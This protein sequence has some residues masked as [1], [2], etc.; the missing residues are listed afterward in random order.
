M[1]RKRS[2]TPARLTRARMAGEDHAVLTIEGGS[3]AFRRQPCSD[4]PWRKDAV[5][6]FPAEAFRHSAPTAYDLGSSTFGCH[7]SG[8][9][10][11]ATCA[12]FL[13]RGAEHNM[14]VRIRERLYGEDYS[15]VTDGGHDLHDDYVAMA[16]ANGVDPDDPVLAPC[17]RGSYALKPKD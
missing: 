9:A 1:T 4:C 13:L 10:K 5:G 7:Q 16:V 3:G 2:K 11:P 6:E 8:Q 15:G 14:Q 12:G 17:R